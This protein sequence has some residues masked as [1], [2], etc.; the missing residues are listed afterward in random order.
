MPI[1]TN[2]FSC[3]LNKLVGKFCLAPATPPAAGP[4]I[5]LRFSS[6]LPQVLKR[7]DSRRQTPKWED[8]L[9]I[10]CAAWRLQQP[11]RVLCSSTSSSHT[12]GTRN[13]ALARLTGMKVLSVDLGYPGFDLTLRFQNGYSFKI[14]CDQNNERDKYENYMLFTS[15][16][17]FTVNYLC[18]LECE[19]R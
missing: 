16:R 17:I 15:D 13:R 3:A 8:K 11:K 10:T 6:N 18:Q 7:D 9:H 2:T 4:W 12:N 14:F 19:R 5:A 1:Q